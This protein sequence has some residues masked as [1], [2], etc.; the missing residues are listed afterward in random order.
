MANT[1]IVQVYGE[2]VRVGPKES[3]GKVQ[4]REKQNVVFAVMD[5][6]KTQYIPVDF[7][8]EDMRMV[9]YI[10]EGDVVNI[11]FKA[12]GY[13]ANGKYWSSYHGLIVEKLK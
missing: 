1:L 9:D 3:F 2:V 6:S 7:Y 10:T 11:S 12:C 4:Q 8:G 5:G 13:V